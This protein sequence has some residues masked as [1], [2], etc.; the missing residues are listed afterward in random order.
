MR[1]FESEMAKKET[2]CHNSNK[3]V[4]N[5]VISNLASARF[6]KLPGT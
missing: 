2:Y 3:T 6:K 4:G 1:D 5:E